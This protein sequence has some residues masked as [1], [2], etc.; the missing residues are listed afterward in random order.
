MVFSSTLF[1]F[2]FLPLFLLVYFATPKIAKNYVSLGFSLFFYAW[3]APEFIFFLLGSCLL[4]FFLVKAVEKNGKRISLVL[5][6]I[7]NVGLLVYFKYANF[8]VENV[9]SLSDSFG[10]G[11]IEWKK[12]ALPIGVSFFTFQKISY[13]L[14]VYRKKS[15]AQ[16]NFAN[17][18]LYITLFPQLI[19]GPIVRY[20]DVVNQLSNRDE[21]IN[22]KLVGMFRFI[23]GLA[24]KVLIANVM[25]AQVSAL[26]GLGIENLTGGQAWLAAIAFTFQIYFDFSGYSDMAIGLGKMIGFK[27]PENFNFPY[28]SR[29][30]TEFWQRW[31]MTLSAWMRDYLYVPLGGN[32]KGPFRTYLNLFL[33]FFISGFWHGAAWNFVVWGCFHGVFLVIERLFLKK[34]LDR[35]P[36]VLSVL[37]C[38]FLVLVGWVF[39]STKTIDQSW[40]LLEKMFSTDMSFATFD[41]RFKF[42][43]FLIV[44][45]LFSFFAFRKTWLIKANNFQ[46]TLANQRPIV[47]LGTTICLSFLLILS[48]AEIVA[49]GFNPFLYYRF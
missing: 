44:A 33:V 23:I 25:G 16:G 14:D 6:L 26:Y 10:M 35:I 5:S 1:L 43:F 15:P 11:G 8:F 46:D 9:N 13:A 41:L 38:F 19:A 39:F 2:Y 48:A 3:G 21:S 24:K 32:R 7:L 36:G 12:I 4:D 42:I 45:V 18:L 34:I 30:I 22:M 27:F 47:V 28:L 17:Y 20:G 29:S 49:D 31:H 37:Y 40:T